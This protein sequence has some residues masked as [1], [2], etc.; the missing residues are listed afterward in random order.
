M[1][2]PPREVEQ[3]V[4]GALEA[5]EAEVEAG[6]G[7]VRSLRGAGSDGNQPLTPGPPAFCVLAGPEREVQASGLASHPGALPHSRTRQHAK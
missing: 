4:E 5:V 6:V 1:T 2:V 7:H 3:E